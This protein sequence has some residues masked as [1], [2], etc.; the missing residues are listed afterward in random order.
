VCMA[1]CA[2][3]Y[4]ALCLTAYSAFVTWP[5]GAYLAA[6]TVG[7]RLARKRSDPFS[8]AAA[9]VLPPIAIGL[10]ALCIAL[11]MLDVG[12]AHLGASWPGRVEDSLVRWTLQLKEHLELNL[13]AF[14][15]IMII[16]LAL[17]RYWPRLRLVTRFLTLQKLG[18]KLILVL[19]AITS[20]TLAAQ[21]PLETWTQERKEALVERYHA[22]LRQ[23]NRNK[24]RLKA[25]A[26]L[27]IAVREM[28]PAQIQAVRSLY[29]ELRNRDQADTR[30]ILR[31]LASQTAVEAEHSPELAAYV[32]KIRPVV[33][34]DAGLPLEAKSEKEF[35]TQERIIH[36]REQAAEDLKLRADQAQEGLRSV[37]VATL[38]AAL[39]G[40]GD[41]AGAYLESLLDAW[42]EVIGEKLGDGKSEELPDLTAR[43]ASRLLQLEDS[44]AFSDSASIQS[45]HERIARIDDQIEKDRQ[46]EIARVQAE[47]IQ[48]II[49]DREAARFR[50]HPIEVI[51]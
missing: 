3:A 28:S 34:A 19:L 26:A 48:K 2:A 7:W 8:K 17:N 21:E 30:E 47:Q 39:P 41:F 18:S 37:F 25:T 5:V 38:R 32:E 27:K 40:F 33:D 45:I 23:I 44:A 12:Q 11:V 15:G 36:A 13:P 24:A 1:V 29:G 14:V 49:Q 43:E 42:A 46:I 16:L 50:E 4:G 31:R 10:L 20:F 9:D 35:L 51:P 6:A 22:S